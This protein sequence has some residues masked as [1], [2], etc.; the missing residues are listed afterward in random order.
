MFAL[1][2][3]IEL[4]DMN[5]EQVERLVNMNMNM[6]NGDNRNLCCSPCEYD[7]FC[8]VSYLVQ[9]K[10]DHDRQVSRRNYLLPQSRTSFHLPRLHSVEYRDSSGME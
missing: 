9:R 4:M 5:E 6:N 3:G 1:Q 8:V 10:E 7:V 2:E